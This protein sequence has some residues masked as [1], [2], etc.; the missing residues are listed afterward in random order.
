M[1][2][3]LDISTSGMIAQRVRLDVA[4]AN[5]AN[6][7][8]LLDSNLQ[9]NPYKARRAMFAAGNPNAAE[10]AQDFGVHIADIELNPAPAQPGE[11]NPDSP[12]AYKTGPWAGYVAKTN[13]NS[14]TESV[15]AI[16]AVRAYEANVMAAE[17]S[18]QMF[19]STMRLLA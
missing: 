13:V 15:N 4:S 9:L 10:G 12:Y 2:G 18:K 7:D 16:E 14:I 17:A 8:S 5:L 6:A 11:W 19:N 1:Y 3:S